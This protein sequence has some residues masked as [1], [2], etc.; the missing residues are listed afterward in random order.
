LTT[1]PAQSPAPHKAQSGSLPASTREVRVPYRNR[2]LATFVVPSSSVS[3]I[4]RQPPA[5]FVSV[6][7]L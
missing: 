7:R 1:L 2:K 6:A 5:H 3:T 4:R